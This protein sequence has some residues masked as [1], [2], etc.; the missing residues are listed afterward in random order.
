MKNKKTTKNKTKAV[1]WAQYMEAWK[2]TQS[3]FLY[4]CSWVAMSFVSGITLQNTF[5]QLVR[6]QSEK[7]YGFFIL[8]KTQSCSTTSEKIRT[9]SGLPVSA[10]DLILHANTEMCFISKTANIYIFFFN[11]S[12]CTPESINWFQERKKVLWPKAKPS[13]R[14]PLLHISTGWLPC[15]VNWTVYTAKKSNHATSQNLVMSKNTLTNVFRN[16]SAVVLVT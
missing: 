3:S 4:P 12:V 5:I 14:W 6:G 13:D 10:K 15:H 9:D 11:A 1:K 16:F 7:C 8:F 2:E